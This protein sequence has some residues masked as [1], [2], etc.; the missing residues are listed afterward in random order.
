MNSIAIV[1]AS[2]QIA[3]DLILSFARNGRTD[4]LL[5]V[6]NLPAATSWMEANGLSGAC[7]L[8][9]Y[10]QYGQLP[11]DAVLNF[12]GVGDPRRAAEMGASIFG[13]T[14]Q[15]DDL[16]L[17]GLDRHPQRRYI[18]LSS[19]AAYGNSFA[20]P[21]GETTEARIA[22]NQ[23]APQDYY[24]TAKLHAEVR[25][26][27][28]P[29]LPIVDL[30]VFNYF[31]RTQD[32]EARFF[33]TDIIRAVRD[34]QLLQTSADYMVRDFLHPEDFYQMVSRILAAPP[35]NCAVDCYSREAVDK[36]TLLEAMRQ[37]FGLRFE[38]A[39]ASLKVGVNATGAKPHYYS[40]SRK[41]AEFGYLP[42]YSSLE[43]VLTEAAALLG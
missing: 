13:I 32:V 42:R 31:S 19:G 10:D 5:Y 3:K 37:R 15:F 24:A 4:L 26:R 23:I 1:G 7:S 40:L 39:S 6:R 20:A 8:Y 12:V 41:A 11:H 21:V 35:R 18:F 14:S 27:S 28:Q 30:R 2:S 43:G 16:I 22:I 17:A 34:G 36:P 9:T 38:S 29:D 25:H 33:I